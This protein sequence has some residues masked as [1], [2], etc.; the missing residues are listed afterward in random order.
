MS[1]ITGGDPLN[2]TFRE[3]LVRAMGAVRAVFAPR[4]QATPE[5]ALNRIKGVGEEMYQALARERVRRAAPGQAPPDVPG[6]GWAQ[7]LDPLVRTDDEQAAIWASQEAQ[8]GRV[9]EAYGITPQ[10]FADYSLSNVTLERIAQ[11]QYEADV[12]GY[13][14]NW[15]DLAFG[16]CRRDSHIQATELAMSAIIYKDPLRLRPRDGSPLAKGVCAFVRTVVEGIQGFS[17]AEEDLFS[18]NAH[19]YS[20][21]E[22]VKQPGRPISFTALGKTVTVKNAITVASLEHVHPRSFRWN[23][24]KRRMY[25]E[26]RGGSYVDPFRDK[27]GR[28]IRKLILHTTVGKGDMHQRGHAWASVPLHFLKSR[29]VAAWAVVLDTLGIQSPYLQYDAEGQLDGQDIVAAQQFLALLGRGKAA[30]LPKR[31]GEVKLTPAATGIDA[32]GQ[33]AAIAGF[34]NSELS[35]LIQGQTLAMEIGGAG[36]YAAA[37][38]QADSKEDRQTALSKRAVNTWQFSLIVWIVE[39]NLYQL[40]DAFGATPD[41]IRAVIPVAYR[42]AS[43]KE[44]RTARLKQFIDAKQEGWVVDPD[45]V[46]D[47]IGLQL[48]DTSADMAADVNWPGALPTVGDEPDEGEDEGEDLSEDLPDDGARTSGSDK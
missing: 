28:E 12:Q 35:K 34:V 2:S 41:Q 23:P 27:R 31:L 4:V 44:D 36:S 17:G 25:M 40:C 1:T 45:Q 47:E 42:L 38:V 14:P 5:Q 8:Y 26:A 6:A 21:L 11:Y 22:I 32:R 24:I 48:V 13:L 18:S 39:D 19:G 7:G 37:N 46:R 3:R 30:F 9:T 33:H 20:G 16:V 15:E 10:S 29:G 43:R